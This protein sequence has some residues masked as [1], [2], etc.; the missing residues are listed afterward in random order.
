MARFTARPEALG[1]K[2]RRRGASPP[3]LYPEA[4]AFR[5][6]PMERQPP[7]ADDHSESQAN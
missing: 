3:P 6:S 7:S 2:A 1:F 5:E 4:A